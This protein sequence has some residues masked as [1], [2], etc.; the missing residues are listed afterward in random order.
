MG[1]HIHQGLVGGGTRTPPAFQKLISTQNRHTGPWKV[2]PRWGWRRGQWGKEGSAFSG[3]PQWNDWP[4]SVR[5]NLGN[6]PAS[7]CTL[8]L[9]VGHATLW[10]LIFYISWATWYP[11]VCSNIIL[12]VFGKACVS[13]RS[14]WMGRLRK[15]DS[16][17]PPSVGA[18]P[19]RLEAWT[20]QKAEEGRIHS[21]WLFSSWDVH[22]HLPLDL[23]VGWDLMPLTPLG[24]PT[25]QN[26]HLG[27]SLPPQLSE[28][29]P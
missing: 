28:P 23:D 16:T 7:C 19:S 2:S 3:S 29:I 9:N 13:E 17:P 12:G 20:E 21:L 18:P 14:I 22:L 6:I 5:G 25:C 10:R 24:L 8:G 27:T 1:C 15:A 26:A 11:D 4:A